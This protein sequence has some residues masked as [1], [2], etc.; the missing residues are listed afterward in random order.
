MVFTVTVEEVPGATFVTVTN[1]VPLMDTDPEAVAVPPQLYEALW[2]EIC[3]VNPFAVGLGVP[4][5]GVSAAPVIE[6]PEVE[7]DPWGKPDLLVRT[8]TVDDVP[9][10]RL[11]T[12][13]SP[14]PL[15]DAVPEAVADADHE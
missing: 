5:V 10:G 14:V 3:T 2:L 8:V 1:P 7:P 11:D 15:I 4:N 13:T 9:G 6:E 12:V